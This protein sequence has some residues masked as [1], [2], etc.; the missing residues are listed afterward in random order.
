MIIDSLFLIRDATCNVKKSKPCKDVVIKPILSVDFNSRG[1]IDFI[2]FQ[3]TLDGNFKWVMNDQDRATKYLY[4]RSLTS[5]RATEVGNE[6]S[7]S[8]FG[9][10]APH[11]LN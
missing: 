6:R 2:N 3:S 10:G 1:Q 11:M 5:K 4:L 9:Q 7:T 8:C